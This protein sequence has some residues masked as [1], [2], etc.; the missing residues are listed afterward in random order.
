M[1]LTKQNNDLNSTACDMIVLTDAYEKS[2]REF[3]DQMWMI[4][5]G[6]W[7]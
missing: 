1:L 2:G 5:N 4:P 6:M 3:I 7:E